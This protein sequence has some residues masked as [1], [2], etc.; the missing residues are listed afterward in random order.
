M[1]RIEQRFGN[2]VVIGNLFLTNGIEDIHQCRDIVLAV[3]GQNDRF[4]GIENGKIRG[5]KPDIAVP[6]LGVFGVF[7]TGWDTDHGTAVKGDRFS[8]DLQNALSLHVGNDLPC[9]VVMRGVTV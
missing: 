6:F 7:H 5:T 8:R 1:N 9:L 3:V 2:H 4:Q